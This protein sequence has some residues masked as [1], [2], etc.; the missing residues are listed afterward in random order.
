MNY[1]R[2][3]WG[4]VILFVTVAIIAGRA[5]SPIAFDVVFGMFMVVA[6]HEV[7]NLFRR[8][9]KPLYM[10][11]VLAYPAAVVVLTIICGLLDVSLVQYILFFVLLT[12]LLFIGFLGFPYVFKGAALKG[13]RAY[14]TRMSFS[15]YIWSCS[16]NSMLACAYPT[17]LLSFMLIINNYHNFSGLITYADG[18]YISM[19]GLLLVFVISMF[20]DTAAYIIGTTIKTPKISMEKLGKGK[21]YSGVAGGILG[22]ILGAAALYYVLTLF[23]PFKDLFFTYTIASPLVFILIGAAGGIFNML[24]DLASSYIKRRAGVKDFGTFIPGH[25]GIM[26]RLNGIAPCCVIVFAFMLVLFA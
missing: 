15:A 14:N 3:I 20:G 7:Y 8:N 21:T 13:Y 19:L 6:A 24:G 22:S 18:Y 11:A 23:D 16:K 9:D 25:G 26:D 4:A 12:S 2:I 17:M 5:L 10:W 1:Q